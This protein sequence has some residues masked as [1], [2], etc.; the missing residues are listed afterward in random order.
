MDRTVATLSIAAELDV[1]ENGR[2]ILEFGVDR[3]LTTE[4]PRLIGSSDIP[5]L[6]TFDISGGFVPN[7]SRTFAAVGYTH[8]I[9]DASSVSATVRLGEAVYGAQTLGF[10]ISYSL[11][12]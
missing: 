4:Q 7:R 12:F 6:E 2:L 8:Q 1:S 11:R 9:N 5:G 10:N 3:D